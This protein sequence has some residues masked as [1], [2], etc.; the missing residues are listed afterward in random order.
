MGR[1]E[2]IRFL[3]GGPLRTIYH[4]L[5][6]QTLRIILVVAGV[7]LVLRW[8]TNLLSSAVGIELT[9]WLTSLGTFFEIDG[10]WFRLVLFGLLQASFFWLAFPRLRWFEERWLRFQAWLGEHVTRRLKEW[11]RERWLRAGELGITAIV[12]ITVASFILQPTLVAWKFDG[13][14]WLH[15]AANLLDGTASYAIVDSVFGVGHRAVAEP[16]PQVKPVHPDT[17][18]ADLDQDEIPLIDRWDAHILRAAEGDRTLAAMT[19]AV[20]WVESGGRQYALSATGCAG[21]MQFCAST[22]QRPPFRAIFGR[23]Q[24]TACGCRSCGIPEQ[25]RIELETDPT[26]PSRLQSQ[27]PCAL[28]DARFDGPKSVEAGAAYVRLLSKDV[29]GHLPLIYVGYNAGPLVARRLYK[30]L[31]EP[32]EL[33]NSDLQPHLADALRPYYGAN[34][35]SRARGLLNVH[36]PKLMRAYDK[37][38]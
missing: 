4:T 11:R 30:A 6:G 2:R 33:S 13:T 31:G 5:V 3:R 26:A 23:G 16:I 34:A 9:A 32:R 29:G 36:L 8:V 25:T 7:G 28:S 22:A 35:D 14:A 21:L 20:M 10:T 18:Y 27:V 38:R 1:S 15:R 24:V 12:T 19:K 17:I 37:W